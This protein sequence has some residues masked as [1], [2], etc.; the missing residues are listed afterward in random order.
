MAPIPAAL[1]LALALLTIG[2]SPAAAEMGTDPS[3]RGSNDWSC[4]P[5]KVHPRPVVLVHGMGSSRSANWGYL[6]PRLAQAGYCVFALTYGLHPD[7]RDWA[8]RPG[9]MTPMQ[10]SSGELARFVHR[11]LRRTGAPRVD[12]VGHSEGTV[13]PRWYLERRGGAR[14]VRRFVALTP[15]W[16]GTDPDVL[17]G[18]LGLIGTATGPLVESFLEICGACPG[19]FRGSDYLR[20][21]NSDGEAVPGIKHVNILTTADEVVRPW[22]SGLM[23]DGGKNI[24]VQEVCP[25][26]SSGHGA[27]AFDPVVV[28]LVLN[29]LKPERARPARC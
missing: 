12:L 18:A 5:S 19:I 23:A 27:V 26:N 29:A 10:E 28:R 3:P 25:A 9:G 20:L 17:A 14:K 6:A 24:V 8:V 4:E 7:T 2:A 22:Q 1:A 16:R 21:L 13:M 15:L 11:V